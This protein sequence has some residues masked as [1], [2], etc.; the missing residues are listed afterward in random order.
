VKRIVILVAGG[1]VVVAMAALAFSWWDRS[2]PT[3]WDK[4]ARVDGDVVHLRYIG[5]LCQDDSS[6]DVE[7]SADE[8]VLTVRAVVRAT[9]CPAVG[10]P[11]E[12]DAHLESPLG[13][14]EL[15]DGACLI[16]KYARYSACSSKQTR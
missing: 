15:V 10:V 11:Y 1:V 7:E 8:V 12:I 13:D 14:R 4:P 6:V 9:T 2:E 16:E 5:S 3:P